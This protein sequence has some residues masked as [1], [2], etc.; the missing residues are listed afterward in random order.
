M[1]LLIRQFE[2][3]DYPNARGLWENTPGVGL[4]SADD[5]EPIERF[6]A[7]NPGLS[8][9]AEN[10][11]VLVGTVLCGHDGRRGLIHHLVASGSY[12]RKGLGRA[13]LRAGLEALR[14][15]GIDKCHLL[16][17]QDNEQGLAF[18][19][20]VSAVERKEMALFSISTISE[21]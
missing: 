3:K 4:G 7:R 1:S 8:F 10:S 12:R 2:A 14:A 13:L 11:G 6:L 21:A 15:A 17:F 19:R 18:W 9:V 16:V 20:S 5:R